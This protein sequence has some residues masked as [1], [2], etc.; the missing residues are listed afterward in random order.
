MRE[1]EF[2]GGYD[3]GRIERLH[4]WLELGNGHGLMDEPPPSQLLVEVMRLQSLS[5][6]KSRLQS[7]RSQSSHSWATRQ[8]Q[9]RLSSSTSSSL[10]IFIYHFFPP[11][12]SSILT[13]PHKERQQDEE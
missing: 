7:H 5:F 13:P 12:T 8:R 10:N 4:T 3:T 6:Y 1:H 9:A 11:R 2:A